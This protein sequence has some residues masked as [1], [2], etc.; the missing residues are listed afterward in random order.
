MS[1]RA[2]RAGA[3][4]SFHADGARAT[5]L[6]LSRRALVAPVRA[7]AAARA[8]RTPAFR[9]R[10]RAAPAYRPRSAAGPIPRRVAGLRGALPALPTAAPHGVLRARAEAASTLRRRWPLARPAAQRT[11]R[12]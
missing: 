1:A 7:G 5:S 6:G 9:S 4:G 2:A 10:R 8:L 12:L 11:R 3:R